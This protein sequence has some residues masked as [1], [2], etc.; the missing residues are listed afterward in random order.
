MYGV[1]IV[2]ADKII[3][4]HPTI[5]KLREYLMANMTLPKKKQFNDL[6]T[7]HD[8]KMNHDGRLAGKYRNIYMFIFACS[9]LKIREYYLTHDCNFRRYFLDDIVKA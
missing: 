2:Y 1:S 7:S 5:T 6:C 3:A 8:S 9:D 4:I